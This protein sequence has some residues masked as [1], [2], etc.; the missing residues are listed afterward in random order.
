MYVHVYV[1]RKCNG[2]YLSPKVPAVACASMGVREINSN[3][4]FTITRQINEFFFSE[5]F[6]VAKRHLAAF[7]D[8]R[9]PQSPTCAPHIIR[10]REGKLVGH[11]NQ[12]SVPR[13]CCTTW[14]ARFPTHHWQEKVFFSGSSHAWKSYLRVSSSVIGKCDVTLSGSWYRGRFL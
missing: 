4:L 9:Y 8:L 14:E 11:G 5:C 12:V 3:S 1:W 10:C 13:S 2:V 7:I 6:S